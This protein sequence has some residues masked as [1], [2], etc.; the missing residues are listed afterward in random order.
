MNLFHRRDRNFLSRYQRSRTAREVQRAFT[1]FLQVASAFHAVPECCVRVLAARPLRVREYVWQRT[2]VRK[3]ITSFGTFLST[4][5]HEFC[6]HLDF[7]QFGFRDSWHTRDSTSEPRRSTITREAS[8]RRNWY[9]FRF[10]V[11]AS[12]LTGSV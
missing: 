10:V 12:V 8:Q 3:D 11:G 4:L 1:E 6:H 2:A 7:Q 5:C 9:G